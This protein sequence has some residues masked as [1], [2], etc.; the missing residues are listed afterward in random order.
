L[1]SQAQCDEALRGLADRLAKI[2]PE[3]RGKYVVDRTVS[4]RVSDLDVTWTGRLCDAGLIGVTTDS[5]TKAQV[6]LTIASD[7]LMSLLAGT[8]A[9][10]SAVAMGKIRVQASPFDLLRLSAFL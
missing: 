4:C 10:P 3:L 2:D 1:A 8:M 5:T 7:D 9:V 6:R